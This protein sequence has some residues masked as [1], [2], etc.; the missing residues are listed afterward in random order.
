M[1]SRKGDALLINPDP[2]IFNGTL[3]QFKYFSNFDR[4]CFLWCVQNSGLCV[5][6]SLLDS[7]LWELSAENS[8]NLHANTSNEIHKISGHWRVVAPGRLVLLFSDS[9]VELSGPDWF[10]SLSKM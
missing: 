3:E 8:Q 4:T 1:Y 7:D 5:G 9:K 6:A 2:F 10:L